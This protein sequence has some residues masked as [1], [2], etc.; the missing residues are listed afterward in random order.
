MS[1]DGGLPPR[2][3]EALAE[4]GGRAGPAPAIEGAHQIARRTGA[5]RHDLLVVLGFGE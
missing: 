4:S 2:L 5:A 1:A 3:L